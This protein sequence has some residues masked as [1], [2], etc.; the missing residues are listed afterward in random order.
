[1]FLKFWSFGHRHRV[2]G[3]FCLIDSSKY[4]QPFIKYITIYKKYLNLEIS[5][6]VLN[7][8]DIHDFD[9]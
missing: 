6:L 9:A 4:S 5:K 3:L 2:G 7:F 8:Q 1:M